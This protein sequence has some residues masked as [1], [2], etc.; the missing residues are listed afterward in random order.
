MP[1]KTAEQ[2]SI[3]AF[4][5]C[6][7][8]ETGRYELVK[9]E[10]SPYRSLFAECPSDQLIICPLPHHGFNIIAPVKYWSLTGRHLFHFPLYYTT[11]NGA[12]HQLDLVTLAALVTKELA[13]F[14]NATG[15]QSELVYRAL[16]SSDN[17]KSFIA[18][19]QA[20]AHEL[21]EPQF[22]FLDAEQSLI[23]GHLL[24]PTPKSRQGLSELDQ[25]L[26]SP[27]QKGKFPLHY[28]RAHRSIV[29]EDSALPQTATQLIKE[30]LQN[31]PELDETF[32]N[33]CLQEDD[34]A[35][36]PLHPFQAE[37]L[38]RRPEVQKLLRQ[39]LIEDLGVM[40]RAYS[41]TSSLRTLYHPQARFMLKCSLHIK[42]T[43]SLRLNQRKELER[44]VEVSRILQSRIGK[45]L[46]EQFPRFQ[47]IQDPAYITLAIPGSKE[48]GFEV[49]LRENPF[50]AGADENVTL[51][52]GLVQDPIKGGKTR[53][54][55]II[56]ELAEKEKRT[57]REV[58]LDWFRRYLNLSLRPLMWL[59]LRY[60]IALEAH[61]Q[62]SL[63]RLY[64]GYPHQFFYRDNQG[65]YYCEST[66]PA[67]K[68]IL[69]GISKKS[70]TV[71]ADAVADER[72]CYYF[73]INHLFGLINVFGASSLIGEQELLNELK[74]ELSR[75]LPWNCRPSTLLDNLLHNEK[76]SCKA[77]LLTRF[78]EMD[79]LAGPLESQSV[80]V[81]IANPLSKV[82]EKRHESSAGI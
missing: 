42:I 75:F 73:F 39:G 52:A 11:A 69:P 47:I 59:Y 43:N 54:F 24:H 71:C 3:E 30:E 27:E 41:P 45:E 35:I 46:A 33:T 32:K 60:G 58:S 49:C 7:L 62:N 67:L 48:S 38:L 18:S 40:G 65:Y 5:N 72:F 50:T 63:I 20:D 15:G 61:Q 2:A 51:I 81:Q 55:N 70:E 66:Y 26:Y 17:I 19:R 34:Y 29:K 53:L 79:E 21:Y 16:Q 28:F 1:D 10:Q 9:K 77:N 80:Y 37:H 76:L 23:F 64:Q 68:R 36:L 14:R 8:R 57:N 13:I 44:G 4:L 82:V 6:Y 78:Y 22:S 31:D 56:S 12:S 74:H 25:A